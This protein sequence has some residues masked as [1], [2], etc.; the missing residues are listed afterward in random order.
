MSQ[1]L[2]EQKITQVLEQNYMP[3]VMSVIMSRAIPEIDGFKPAH[4]KLLYTMY[5]MNLLGENRTKSANVVGQTMKLNPHGDQ[6]IYATMVRMSRGYDALLHPYVDSKG[7]FGKHTSRD[8]ACA[9]SRY[10]EVR[11]A[12]ICKELFK[13]IEKNTVSF[14]DNYDG[15]LKE[16]VLLPVRFPNV[17]IHANKGIA[18]G[19][20]SSICSFNL[21]E[22]CNLTK[23][24]LKDEAVLIKDYLKGPDFSTGGYLIRE[25]ASLDK[26]YETGKGSFYLQAVY[27]YNKEDHALEITEIPYTTT[28]EAIMD[29]ILQLIQSGK[30]KEIQDMRDETDLKG[31]KLTID[32]KRGVEPEKFMT[33][34]FTM[35]PLRDSFSCNFNILVGGNPKVMGIK[36]ILWEWVKFRLDCLKNYLGFMV[37]QK[38]RALH[39]LL[40]LDRVLLDID[41]AIQIIRDTEDDQGVVSNLMAAFHIDEVQAEFVADIKLR[42]LNKKYLLDKTKEIV[43]LRDDIDEMKYQMQSEKALKRIISNELD[44]VSKKYGV[45]RKTQILENE[46]VETY[47]EESH[48]EKYNLKVFV[49]EHGYIKKIP[50]VSLRTANSQKLKE[51]DEIL[52]ELNGDNHSELLCF[53][54]KQNVYKIWAHE[55]P[56]HKASSLGEYAA[57]VFDMAEDE[58]ILFAHLAGHYE[59]WFIFVYENGK[60]AKVPVASY[61]TKSNRK[62]LVNGF[63]ADAKPV[64]IQYVEEDRLLLME[65]MV[66]GNVDKTLV[67]STG[68]ISEK[69]SRSTKGIQVLRLKKGASIKRAFLVNEE[70]RAKV[71]GFISETI[72]SAGQSGQVF[73]VEER[74]QLDLFGMT[75]EKE[76]IQDFSEE[77]DRIQIQREEE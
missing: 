34:L 47:R 20:A 30:I 42:N 14:V 35:T 54:D 61:N 63:C 32:L 38:E 65:R 33:K 4:R 11:L 60:V 53:T 19:M 69:V 18:V 57:N 28:V 13:D 22:V 56:D 8:M 17:L 24:Y 64:Y 68:F 41:K 16:P 72:P 48:I 67:V 73:D 40:G 55:L 31:L 76:E 58:R 77:E 37:E 12:P 39:L 46:V 1:R 52:F 25:E 9:A 45:E 26:I 27:A 62:K 36:E 5:K 2:E 70:D 74:K 75:G 23:A 50:L 29:K 66:K 51:E 59:G 6:A 21:K 3:Y 43:G 7:N 15:K 71:E 44:E 10:T 49:T